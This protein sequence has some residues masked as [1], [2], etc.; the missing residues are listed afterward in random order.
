MG[1][2]PS[3]SQSI[4]NT[5]N[6][7]A[8]NNIVFEQMTTN[9]ASATVSGANIQN[10]KVVLGK[11]IGCDLVFNQII[12][13]EVSASTEVDAVTSTEIKNDIAATLAAQATAALENA[14]QMGSELGALVSGETDQEI[15][16]E[17]N[18]LVETN[19][20]NVIETI[21]I[22]ETVAESVNIQGGELHLL[23]YDCTDTSAKLDFTQDITAKAAAQAVTRAVTDALAQ[24]TVVA[25]LA[26][27]VEADVSQSRGGV[28]QLA[29]SI[30]GG[31]AGVLGASSEM[32]MFS[33]IAAVCCCCFLLIFLLSPAGQSGSSALA[34]AGAS[35]MKGH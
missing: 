11:I 28:A 26:A 29:D 32:V 21:N 31:I 9:K 4:E 6:M 3:T 16:T 13:S 25:A 12:S 2:A 33:V 14:S 8:V 7:Q 5:F 15:R 18:Q 35:R 19:I 10:L 22:S 30:F 24:N 27:T 34:N 17:V 1:P 23:Y 20:K